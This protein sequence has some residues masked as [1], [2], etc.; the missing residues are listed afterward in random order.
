MVS[1]TSPSRRLY[2]P[3]VISALQWPQIRGKTHSFFKAAKS[4]W[5]LHL[6]FLWN[7]TKL[8]PF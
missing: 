1:K 7:F 2:V 8:P 5:Q 3:Q 4:Q 6:W